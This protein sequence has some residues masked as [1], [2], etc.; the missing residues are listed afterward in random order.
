MCRI[1]SFIFKHT[2]LSQLLKVK[3]DKGFKN[4]LLLHITLKITGPSIRNISSFN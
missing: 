2:E 1:I 4:H 3:P